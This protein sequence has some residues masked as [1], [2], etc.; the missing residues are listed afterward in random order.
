MSTMDHGVYAIDNDAWWDLP[1]PSSPT[2]V[3][4][5]LTINSILSRRGREWNQR[6]TFSKQG[7]EY[8]VELRDGLFPHWVWFPK[9]FAVDY[10]A[11]YTLVPPGVGNRLVSLSHSFFTY[12]LV[13]IILVCWHRYTMRRAKNGPVTERTEPNDPIVVPPKD[14]T[15]DFDTTNR[16]FL[17]ELLYV[18]FQGEK[19]TGTSDRRGMILP[20]ASLRPMFNIDSDWW[21]LPDRPLDKGEVL[22][23][24]KDHGAQVWDSHGEIIFDTGSVDRTS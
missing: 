11:D 10:V 23:V 4:V 22:F 1:P 15:T 21:A 8:V 16:P 2:A 20:G 12:C 18:H 9:Q 14:L 17:V 6:P 24:D 7:R 13:V 5:R 3:D 19:Y